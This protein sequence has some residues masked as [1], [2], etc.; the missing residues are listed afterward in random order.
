M[1]HGSVST[2][3]QLR[4]RVSSQ[5]IALRQP[6]IVVVSPKHGLVYDTKLVSTNALRIPV[7]G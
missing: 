2:R 5:M 1:E 6:A 7:G 3:S 4:V